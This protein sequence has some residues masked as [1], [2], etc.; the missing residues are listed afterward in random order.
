MQ[1]SVPLEKSPFSVVS[2]YYKDSQLVKAW[3]INECG[4]LVPK[5]DFYIIHCSLH[6]SIMTCGPSQNCVQRDDKNHRLDRT[7]ENVSSGYGTADAI[8]NL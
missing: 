3:R 5:C 7:A 8:M 6:L 2:S 4:V 1:L